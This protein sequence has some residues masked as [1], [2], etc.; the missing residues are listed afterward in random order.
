MPDEAHRRGARKVE[1]LEWSSFRRLAIM[2]IQIKGDKL[3]IE[4]DISSSSL[5]NGLNVTTGAGL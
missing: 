5:K 2:N 4:A 1:S 3:Y